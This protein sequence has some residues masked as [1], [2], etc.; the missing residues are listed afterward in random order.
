M[1][2]AGGAL[3]GDPA[4]VLLI[5]DDLEALAIFEQILR[6]H[7]FAVRK[8]A[9]AEEGL[10][11]L[12][13][14]LPVTIVMDLRLPALDGLEGLRRIRATPRYANIPVTVITADYLVDDSVVA[15]IEAMGA[16]M[17]F[18]PIWEEDLLRIVRE[19][20]GR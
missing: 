20:T 5:E 8:A 7:G 13:S 10:L 2:M 17:C 14:G 1:T 6:E 19:D 16:H 12:E 11:E 18:K 3:P 4:P 9:S 15:Q